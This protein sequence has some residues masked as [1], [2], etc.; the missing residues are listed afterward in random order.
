MCMNVAAYVVVYCRLI[1]PLYYICCIC[2]FT[3]QYIC[4][5]QH[6]SMFLFV[7]LFYIHETHALY[8]SIYF[9]VRIRS[10]PS[11]YLYIYIYVLVCVRIYIYIY[12]WVHTYTR[13]QARVWVHACTH[14]YM[15]RIAY[16]HAHMVTS[17]LPKSPQYQPASYHHDLISYR[18]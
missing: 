9:H 16:V 15:H 14:K 13:E 12:T 5:Y 7:Y 4:I 1:K 2:N 17:F 11:A 8:T 3:L 6:I 18:N 10:G